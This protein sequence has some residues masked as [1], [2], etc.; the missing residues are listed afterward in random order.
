MTN[1]TERLVAAA[2]AEVIAED[3]CLNTLA[4]CSP[5]EFDNRLILLGGEQ[6]VAIGKANGPQ[7]RLLSEQL[8]AAGLPIPATLASKLAAQG[9]AA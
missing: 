9:E 6:A 2:I 5:E 8:T 3:S 4:E 1:E 7:L